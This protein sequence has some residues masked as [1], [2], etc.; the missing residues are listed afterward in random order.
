[1]GLLNICCQKFEDPEPVRQPKPQFLGEDLRENATRWNE[2]I[3]AWIFLNLEDE[4]WNAKRQVPN[5]QAENG[6]AVAEASGTLQNNYL[7][8]ELANPINGMENQQG[9]GNGETNE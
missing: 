7:Q 5:Q 4:V 6:A 1:M 3:L 8:D 9:T 2:R